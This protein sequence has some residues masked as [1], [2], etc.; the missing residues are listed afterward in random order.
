MASNNTQRKEKVKLQGKDLLRS[1]KLLKS[2][3]HP[4]RLWVL[5]LLT[6]RERN[7]KEIEE[8]TGLNQPN[9]SRYLQMLL[10]TGLIK[11]RREG[12]RVFYSLA[13]EDVNQVLSTVRSLV[14]DKTKE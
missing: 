8:E 13:S 5:S 12:V 2:L 11:R 6:D 9:I 10:R 4:S 1:S 7:V 3:S 14:E